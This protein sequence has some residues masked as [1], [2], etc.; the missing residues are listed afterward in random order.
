MRSLTHTEESQEI[1]IRRP[2]DYQKRFSVSGCPLFTPTK[3][4]KSSD[5]STKGEQWKQNQLSELVKI[6]K[7]CNQADNNPPPL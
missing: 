5:R 7:K 4:I 6:I 1:S 3:N 2:D